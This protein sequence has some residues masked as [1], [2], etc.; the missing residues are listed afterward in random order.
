[1]AGIITYHCSS[2]DCSFR[3]GLRVNFPIW[4]RFGI[5]RKL[6][7]SRIGRLFI[8]GYKSQQVCLSCKKTVDVMDGKDECPECTT[9]ANFLEV[10]APCPKCES[11]V[12]VLYEGGGV[13]F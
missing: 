13:S 5:S 6:P 8:K 9:K 2:P 1:M 10:D 4:R 12:A 11:G 3:V 7:V